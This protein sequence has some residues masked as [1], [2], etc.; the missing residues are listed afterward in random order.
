MGFFP[1]DDETLAYLRFTGR[2]D[3][4]VAARRALHQG[5]PPLAR[6]DARSC[7]SPTR[8]RSISATVEPSLAGPARPQ[9]RVPLKTVAPRLAPRR[10]RHPR[11]QV[12]RRRHRDRRVVERGRPRRARRRS[13]S[14]SSVTTDTG[15]VRARARL[16]RDRRDH[17]L[18]EHVEPVGADRP[19]A[20]SRARPSPRASPSKPWVKT[21][22]A[23]GSQVVTDYLTEAG[24]MADLETARLPPRRLR[25]HDLHR[26]LGPG[27]RRHRRGGQGRQP[28][29]RAPCCP[30]NR[31]FE[32]RVNPV[33]RANYLASPPLVVAYALAGTM[34][35]DL[36]TEPLGTGQ[37]RQAGVP[38]RRL[39]VARG[40]RRGDAHR[41]QARAVPAALRARPRRRRRLARAAGPGRRHLRVGRRL[42][43]HPQADASSTTSARR[44]SRSPTSPARACSRSSATRSP[45]ITS[46][47]PAT[48][49]RA[50]PPRRYLDA[51][52]RPAGR[53]QPVRRAPRQ[54]R[55]HGARHVRE[56]PAQEPDA[57]RR[58]GRLHEVLRRSRRDRAAR[59]LRRRDE[60]RRGRRARSS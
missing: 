22:L 48:S 37:R 25:L 59:D 7:G 31:N 44:R 3:E 38:A 51:A 14:R 42:D 20:C 53:L 18:H 33:V 50:A 43:V 55:G 58:R 49:R 9:D 12:R 19:R 34:N 16:G 52:R 2:T 60:V 30:G 8:C 27:P 46:R 26:Q 29:R 47:P 17:E 35:I 39:A 15:H 45:P 57:R 21:S 13:R 40:G 23:P 1:V 10:R 28:R 5:E 24:V 6:P 56:H 32:G 36:E 54:P 4:H 11:R 41:D